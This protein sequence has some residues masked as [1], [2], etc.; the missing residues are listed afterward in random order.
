MTG[1]QTCALPICDVC[2]ITKKY[3]IDVENCDYVTAKFAEPVP[4]GIC[5]AFWAQG[6]TDNVGI[7]AGTFEYKYVFEDDAKCAIANDVLPQITMLTLWNSQTVKIVGIYKHSTKVTSINAVNAQREN[8]A[9][10]NLNGQKVN[11]TQKG[12][13]IVDG[14][15]VVIK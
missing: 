11:K 10:Y 5:I 7:P 9:I 13:Y 1:V 3:D 14:K 15:K 8:G 4:A 2:V 12:L 6:G